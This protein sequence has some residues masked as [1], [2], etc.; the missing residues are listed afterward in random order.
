MDKELR[1]TVFQHIQE[2]VIQFISRFSWRGNTHTAPEDLDKLRE[3]FRQDYYVI[4]TRR[5]NSVAA[6]FINLGHFLLRGRWGFYTHVLMNMEDTAL[7]DDDFRFVEAT[8]HGTKYSTFKMITDDIDAIALLKPKSMT[9]AEWTVALDSV[10]KLI[11][12]PYDNL[13]DLSN[14]EE[15]N[16]V[17]LIRIALQSVPG[18]ET[19]F[20]AFEE[21]CHRYKSITP[22]MFLECP[23][24]EV[25]LEIG[26]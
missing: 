23:D 16:C 3:M 21:M 4:A 26:R 7:T 8:T 10:N 19:R 5:K 2:T 12:S 6:F 15:I 1:K 22:Q 14:T 17:E 18:Y 24:F 20:A 25:V 9:V 13:F 11:G